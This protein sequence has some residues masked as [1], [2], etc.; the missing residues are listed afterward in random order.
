MIVGAIVVEACSVGATISD[1][2]NVGVCSGDATVGV[3]DAVVV[4]ADIAR[5]RTMTST[6]CDIGMML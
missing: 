2:C 1:A 5:L 6:L 4:H 3:V